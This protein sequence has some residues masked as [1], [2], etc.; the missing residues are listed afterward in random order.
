MVCVKFRILFKKGRRGSVI[1]I[2]TGLRTGRSGVRTPISV[3]ERSKARVC[4]RSLAGIAG[5]NPPGGMD[6][7]VVKD[8]RQN[9]DNPVE[10][11]FSAPVQT[12]PGAHPAPIQWVPGVKRLWRGVHHPPP[13]GAEVRE[14]VELY[15]YT[16]SRPSWPVT[17]FLPYVSF[18]SSCTPNLHSVFFT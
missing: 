12:G 9:Q 8:K 5:L 14:R 16:P 7:C 18:R 15:L 1:G 17:F 2:V 6:V 10:A 11:R 13:S 4:D 3:A